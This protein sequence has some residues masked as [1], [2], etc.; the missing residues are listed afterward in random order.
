M[1]GDVVIMWHQG[2]K[3][4]NNAG[5]LCILGNSRIS[6]LECFKK[7]KSRFFCITTD[8]AHVKLYHIWS[9]MVLFAPVGVG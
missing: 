8:I 7:K 4:A 3:N 1:E 6:N 9:R 2:G 5:L